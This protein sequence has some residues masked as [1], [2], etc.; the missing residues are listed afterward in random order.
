MAV[1][2]KSIIEWKTIMLDTSVIVSLFHS[3][4][5]NSK[6]ETVLFTR[7]LI[8]YLNSSNSGNGKPRK[9]IISSIVLTELLVKENDQEK[10]KRILR[11][12]NSTNVEFVD[13]DIETS[14]L[15][16]Y[17]LYPYLSKEKLHKF[18]KEF[19]FKT[20][21]YMMAREWINRDFMIIMS[22]V[23]NN[24]DVILTSDHRTFYPL[25]NK[26]N[27]FCA[28]TRKDLFEKPFKSVLNYYHEKAKSKHLKILKENIDV[29]EVILVQNSDEKKK[30]IKDP[31]KPIEDVKIKD[32]ETGF[33]EAKVV[34]NK[35][36]PKKDDSK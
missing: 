15:F 8:D 36:P 24:A 2:E 10:I 26:A 31:L 22:G 7:E 23:S 21:D 13:F 30:N 16:N 32:K 11:V 12:L 29:K 25:A 17:E 4:N 14:L 3:E 6:D 34:K 28:L 18:A 27:A 20:N 5:P 9:F 33:L 35:E 1:N 19:G